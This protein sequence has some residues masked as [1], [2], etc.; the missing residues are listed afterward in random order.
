MKG[1]NEISKGSIYI[2][3]GADSHKLLIQIDENIRTKLSLV[4]CNEFE[5]Y[6]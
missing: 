6:W 2:R 4:N 5:Y 1:I 3:L